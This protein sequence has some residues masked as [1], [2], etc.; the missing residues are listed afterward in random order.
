MRKRCLDKEEREKFNEERI[1][2]GI[3]DEDMKIN[4][5]KKDRE[6]INRNEKVGRE[7]KAC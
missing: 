3:K 6:R 2:S 7:R 5:K 1:E 4:D